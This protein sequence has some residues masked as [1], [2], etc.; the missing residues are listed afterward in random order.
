MD[1]W[2]KGEPVTL[3]DQE[4]S[5]VAERPDDHHFWQLLLAHL[6]IHSFACEGPLLGCSSASQ[7]FPRCVA[8]SV[9]CTSGRLRGPKGLTGVQPLLSGREALLAVLS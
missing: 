2:R 9:R 4:M 1:L 5:S 3:L 6:V 8:H 7:Y